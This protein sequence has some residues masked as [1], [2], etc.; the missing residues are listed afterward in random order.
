MFTDVQL[1][2]LKPAAKAYRR[3]DGGGL[4]IRVTPAGN[5]LWRLNYRFNGKQKT[6]CF[7][8]Y[9]DV[10]LAD[11]R[12]RREAA[13]LRL[14]QGKDP[15]AKAEKAATLQ[16]SIV[17][18]YAD[19]AEQGVTPQAFLYRH[20]EPG[21]DLLYVGITIAIEKRTI[22][23]MRRAEWRGQIFMIVIEPFAT[24][25]EA[26]AAERKAIRS[27]FPKFNLMHNGHRHPVRELAEGRSE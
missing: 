18:K 2:A 10:T 21:G 17:A 6:L 20:Y 14:R 1:R 22:D 19:L 5:R 26:L 8:R 27:E 23:H 9:P 12:A 24:R 3:A 7:G 11:A 15:S 25:D 13:K 4:Y 16:E